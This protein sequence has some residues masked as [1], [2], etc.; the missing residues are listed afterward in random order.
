MCEF[1]TPLFIIYSYVSVITLALITSFS[2]F[3]NDRKNS[4]NRNAFYFISIIALWTIGDLVQWTTE[5]ASVSYIFFRLSYLVDFFY[6][7]FLYFAY[8]MVGK[9]LG[10][11][12]KLVFA[13]PLS[14]TVFAVAKKYAIGSVDPE[15]CEYALGWY[16]YVSLFLNLAYALWAS[17]ILL[18]KYFD[19][20]IWHNKKKQIRILVFAIMSFVLWSIAY[21]ALDL[22]RIAEKM[23]IDISPYFILGNL[24]FL[25]LIVLAVIEY[26][27]FDF[28]VLPRKWFVFSI[29]SAIFWGMFFLTLTPVF[30]S[31]LLIFYVA[32]IW[33][34]WG[35]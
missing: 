30:Y 26:E 17:M 31:I 10:W 34:F 3:L 7:F 20:F 18:R 28:K 16:I 27:L 15:T 14:L 35:K 21:E 22:F 11:K 8:A 6:L 12:K 23:Q 1:E 9:E 29:F 32:I 25:T 4:Q 2:I 24:F 19:P 33:I 5:S 13:L